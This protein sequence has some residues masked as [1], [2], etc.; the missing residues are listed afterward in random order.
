LKQVQFRPVHIGHDAEQPEQAVK[1]IVVTDSVPLMLSQQP[2]VNALFPQMTRGCPEDHGDMR[3][4]SG[5]NGIGEPLQIDSVLSERL[6][7]VGDVQ[8]CRG[9]A[10]SRKKIDEFGQDLIGVDNGVVIGIDDILPVTAL[11]IV[12]AALRQEHLEILRAP[13][14]I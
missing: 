14:V 10:L 12:P 11:H 6:T 1:Q 8:H 2:P 4:L 9:I 5:G 7:V 3:L 13:L